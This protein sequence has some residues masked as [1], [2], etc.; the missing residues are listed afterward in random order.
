M[1]AAAILGLIPAKGHLLSVLLQEGIRLGLPYVQHMAQDPTGTVSR[2]GDALVWNGVNGQHVLAGI[3]SAAEGQARIE[4]VVNHI[5]SVQLGISHALGVM[6]TLSIATLGI[7][8]LSGLYMVWRFR[9]LNKRFD[10]LSVAIRDVE[11]NVAAS[12]KAHLTLAVG[13]LQIFD[14][15][16]DVNDLI[17]AR[18]QG[19]QAASIYGEMALAEASR[20][21]PRIEVLNYRTRCYLLALMAELQSRILL[22]ELP[23]VIITRVN[24]ETPCLQSLAKTTFETVIQN[25]PELYLRAKMA[26]EGVTLEL[27]TELYKQAL[28]AG[29]IASPAV[30][31]AGQLFEHCRTKGIAS[32]GE[33]EFRRDTKQDAAHLRYLMASLEEINRINGMRLM[34]TEANEKKASIPALRDQVRDWWKEKV[35]TPSDTPDA[36]IAYAFV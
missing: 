33:W 15:S 2:I 3:A 18:D 1:P 6:H 34:I 22:S 29:A 31:S 9:S 4:Q 11:D 36:V 14:E 28:T 17:N 16:A 20:K 8:A 26:S 10:K 12:N 24:N 35:G 21:Q 32:V 25:K 30:E 5:D 13:N 27:M 23:S 7:T 19:F